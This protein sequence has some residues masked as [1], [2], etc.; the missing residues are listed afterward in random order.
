MSNS[1]TLRPETYRAL[2]TENERET[3]LPPARE[4]LEQP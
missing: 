4:E 2:Q 1:K 3:E